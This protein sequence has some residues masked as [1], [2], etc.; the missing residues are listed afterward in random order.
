MFLLRVIIMFASAT[1]GTAPP[2]TLPPWTATHRSQQ[3]FSKAA[4]R[5]VISCFS[6]FICALIRK[7]VH[8]ADANGW[9]PLH[10]ASNNDFP[11]I[12]KLLLQHGADPNVI[13]SKR[14][15]TLQLAKSEKVYRLLGLRDSFFFRDWFIDIALGGSDD[16]LPPR[17]AKLSDSGSIRKSGSFANISVPSTIDGRLTSPVCLSVSTLSITFFFRS[18]YR[19]K[20]VRNASSQSTMMARTR[21]LQWQP[22]MTLSARGQLGGVSIATATTMTIEAHINR[23]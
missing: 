5:S 11:D 13:D 18:Y 8:A 17:A 20:G 2:Y 12:V 21:T 4:Q 23:N 10:W 16:F 19:R 14:R 3:F 9:T 1:C 22:R 6:L 15:T 7:Q